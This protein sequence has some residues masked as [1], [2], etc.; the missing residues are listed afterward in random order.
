[1]AASTNSQLAAAAEGFLKL[2][3]C[4]LILLAVSEPTIQC[5]YVGFTY[6]MS[7]CPKR[8]FLPKDFFAYLLIYAPFFF[9]CISD[10]IATFCSPC[11][12]WVNR[13]H[14]AESGPKGIAVWHNDEREREN[15]SFS[16]N[17]CF[18]SVNFM[19]VPLTVQETV[20]SNHRLSHARKA[21]IFR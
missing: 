12:Q 15:Q 5:S 10:T 7:R 2:L 20:I 16:T 21:V 9:F 6:G 13:S 4:R 17:L 11:T 19:S 1:M 3:G 8:R 18:S 14:K